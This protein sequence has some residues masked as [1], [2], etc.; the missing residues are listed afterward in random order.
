MT[1]WGIIE[2]KFKW[3]LN[4]IKSGMCE[5]HNSVNFTKFAFN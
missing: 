2:L 5:G 3:N 4:E 1:V